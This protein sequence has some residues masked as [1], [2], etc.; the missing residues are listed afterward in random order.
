VL[1]LP[2]VDARLLTR[3]GLFVEPAFLDAEACARLRDEMRASHMETATVAA[4][5]AG[6]AVD[7]SQRRTKYAEISDET[8]EEVESRFAALRPNLESY[9]GVELAGSQ[10]PQ[11]L[12]YEEGDYFGAHRDNTS[13]R[14]APEHARERVLSAVVFLNEAS[15]EPRP[16]AYG[17]GALSFYG[18]LEG[19][20]DVGLPLEAAPGLLVA[21]RSEVPHGVSPVTHG[22][23]YTIVSWFF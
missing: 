5:E 10:P 23:R 17:G 7:E 12:V 19:R 15:A 14:D 3:F 13:E 20:P 1:T 4:S 21:F 22:E 18:L 16:G 11:F 2:R 6:D 9:F 8:F